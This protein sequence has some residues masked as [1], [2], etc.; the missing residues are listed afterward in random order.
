MR[1]CLGIV[2]AMCLF[3]AGG[4]RA[5]AAPLTDD[6]LKA[7]LENL[8]YTVTVTGDKAPRHFKVDESAP[9][10]SLD[11]TITFDLS[12]AKD[13]T[14]LW[15]YAGLYEIPAGK[16]APSSA[17]LALLAK[18]DEIGPIFFSYN[19]DNKLLYLNAPTANVDITPAVLRQKIK[20]FIGRMDST[21]SLWNVK[22]WK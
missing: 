10:N 5:Q 11:F 1:T 7:M 17:L 2:M 6:T 8:G 12:S 16:P 18:N 4:V 22:T 19:A 9:I 13:A 21:Y 15:I 3:L 14:V 20:T